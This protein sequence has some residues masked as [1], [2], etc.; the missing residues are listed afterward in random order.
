M[1]TKLIL[2]FQRDVMAN[3]NR[4]KKIAEY[5]ALPV[6][7]VGNKETCTYHDTTCRFLQ[8]ANKANLVNFRTREEVARSGYKPCGTCLK[9]L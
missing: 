7:Y 4:K 8:N 6:L 3:N 1:D 5:M 2:Q 9:H